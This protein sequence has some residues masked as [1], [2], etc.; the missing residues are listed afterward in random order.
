MQHDREWSLRTVGRDAGREA[1]EA[2]LLQYLKD[3]APKE[4][5]DALTPHYRE[6]PLLDNISKGSAG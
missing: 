3:K 1:A 5:L 4:Y 2:E 6:S